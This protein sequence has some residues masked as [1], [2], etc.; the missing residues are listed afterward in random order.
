MNSTWSGAGQ[1]DRGAGRGG[2]QGGQLVLALD[3]DVEQVHLEP[4]GH[5]HAGEVVRRRPVDG[6]D[7]VR[8]A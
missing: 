6:V 4:D 2:E 1:V 5:G 8:A 3:A 7:Q